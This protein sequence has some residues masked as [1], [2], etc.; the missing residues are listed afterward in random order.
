KKLFKP[1]VQLDSRLNRQHEGTGLGLAL[2]QRLA[3]LHGGSIEV[4]SAVGKGSRFTVNLPMGQNALAQNE[5]VQRVEESVDLEQE[6]HTH[7]PSME[8]VHHGTILLAEDNMA[9]ILTIAE[10]LESYG[11]EIVVVHDGIEAIEKAKEIQPDLILMDIQMPAMD[12][13]EAMRRLRA[14][15]RFASTPIIALTALAM[16]GDRERCLTAGAS[17]YM[18]KPVRLKMLV[19]TVRK[20]LSSQG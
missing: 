9:N 1:F 18:S 14:D 11:Y 12:G 17:E 20:L 5:S 2:V 15:S 8:P 19:K 3:D 6:E 10:Y 4:E 13:L 16:P 7:A